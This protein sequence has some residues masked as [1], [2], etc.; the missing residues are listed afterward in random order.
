MFVLLCRVTEILQCRA[1]ANWYLIFKRIQ[2]RWQNSRFICI[3]YCR[4]DP[5]KKG[6]DK[7]KDKNFKRERK[8]GN[9]R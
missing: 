6:Y 4:Q 3:L 5:K 1:T 8:E 9:E 2:L 7:V